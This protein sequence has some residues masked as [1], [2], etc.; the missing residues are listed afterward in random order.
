MRPVLGLFVVSLV[1][2]AFALALQLVAIH[3]MPVSV[4]ET[5]KRGLGSVAAL[6]LGRLFFSELLNASR[7]LAVVLMTAGV[8]LV[9]L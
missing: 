4:V 1:M 8:A 6:V 2:S 5:V 3:V 7:V 9:L